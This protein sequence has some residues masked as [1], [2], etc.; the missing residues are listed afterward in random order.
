MMNP[1]QT[2][3]AFVGAFID[4]LVRAGVRHVCIC[5]GSRSTPLAMVCAAQPGLRVWM[6]VDERSAG[7]FALGMARVL[8]EPVALVCTS[9]TA[10][11]NF[12]PAVVEAYYSRVPLIVLTADRPHELR[13]VGANQTMDQVRLYGTHVKWFVDMPLPEA[14]STMLRYARTCASRAA[15][16][17]RTAPAGPVHLNFPLRE[18]LVPLPGP[19]PDAAQAAPSAWTGRADGEPYTAVAAGERTLPGEAVKEL[20]AELGAARRGVIVCGP[21]TPADAAGPI[22]NLAWRLGWPV[23]ADPLSGLRAVPASEGG[24]AADEGHTLLDHPVIDAYDVFLRD[25]RAVEALVPEVILRF[26]AFPV[27]KPLLLYLERWA[28][29]RQIVVDPGAQWR[30][31]LLAAGRMVYADPA[32]LCR[33]L[34][35][36]DLDLHRELDI[37]LDRPA[38]GG[39]ETSGAGGARRSWL[40][41][42][43]ALNRATRE[44]LVEQVEALSEPFEG[45]VFHELAAL[46]P[47]G[48]V[49]YVGNSMPIRDMDAFFPCIG[50]PVRVLGNRGTSGIDGVVSS[51]L[52]A[53][54]AVDGP[55]VLVLGD[56]SF[57]HDLNGLLAAKLHRLNVTIVVINN[58]GGGIFSFLPQAAHP[59]HFETLFGTPLG[60]DFRPAVEMYGGRFA[61]ASDWDAFRHAVGQA[62][63]TPGLDVIEVVT[64]RER[65]WAL[66]RQVYDAVLQGLGS[67]LDAAVSGSEV[68]RS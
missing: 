24:R 16:L 44:R 20:A 33:A 61:R 62:V 15:A 49:L 34:L 36:L 48:T 21:D 5:P 28:E 25:R 45:R 47:A 35:E 57:Y 11:A 14:T 8:G 56:L 26:G 40:G 9:G 13:D 23:L 55:V 38:L 10:A 42:W 19:L 30:D 32:G 18:P 6:H 51:A 27:S 31:P 54:A 68:P 46:L 66:H 60:L 59:E 1:Q 39:P 65:N 58:D 29:K 63:V 22:V 67:V 41:A 7:F 3:H 52:G 50:R 2:I 53:A 12:L 4:E 17:A 43:Q 64:Q 37:A